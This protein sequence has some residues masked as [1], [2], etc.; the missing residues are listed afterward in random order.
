MR[1]YDLIIRLDNY[2]IKDRLRH[3]KLLRL[4]LNK[5]IYSKLTYYLKSFVICWRH[6]NL[7]FY[8]RFLFSREAAK[9]WAAIPQEDLEPSQ[10][11][12]HQEKMNY[13]EGRKA[14][15]KAWMGEDYDILDSKAFNIG[16][17]EQAFKDEDL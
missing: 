6:T 15:M 17:I 1:L 14:A 10:E 4:N 9:H 8:E 2:D 12:D 3:K 16:F 11:W 5:D 13:Y 7:P